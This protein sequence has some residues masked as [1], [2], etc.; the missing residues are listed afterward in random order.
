MAVS[1]EILRETRRKRRDARD[2]RSVVNAGKQDAQSLRQPAVPRADAPHAMH[3]P[4]R[5]YLKWGTNGERSSPPNSQS[6][7]LSPMV[8]ARV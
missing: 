3:G 5:E 7:A 2:F 1:C 6:T 4:E 8:P